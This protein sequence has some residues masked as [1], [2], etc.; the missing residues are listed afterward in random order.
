MSSNIDASLPITGSPTTQ[1]VRDNFQHAK[2]EIED[3]QN[4]RDDTNA[5][6]QELFDFVQPAGTDNISFIESFKI[7]FKNLANTVTSYFSNT[8]TAGRTYLFPDKSG[9]VAMTSDI[10]SAGTLTYDTD[11]TLATNSDG[12]LP[13]QKAVK[14]YVDNAVTGLLDFKG[15]TNCSTNPN[16]PAALKGDAYIVTTAGK[17]GGT[18][19]IIVDVSDVYVASADNAGGTQATVGA[20]WFVLEHN[21]VGAELTSNKDATGGYTGLTLFKINFKNAANTFISFFT[22]T[23]TAA[24]TY[25][26]QDRDGTIADN[27]DLATKASLTGTETLT[28]KSLQ[29]STTFIVDDS[30]PT[31]KIKFQVSGVTTAT[32]R[33]ITMPDKD[34]TLGASGSLVLLR[35]ITPAGETNEDFLT[36]F[37]TDYDNYI[38]MGIGIVPSAANVLRMRFAV[39]GASD[40]ASNYAA[41]TTFGAA[42]ST[43]LS[44]IQLTNATV[45]NT[46]NGVNFSVAIRNVND[47]T[48]LKT[49]KSD[50]TYQDSGTPSWK[51]EMIGGVYFAANTITGIRIYWQSGATFNAVGKIYLYGIKNN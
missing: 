22:N 2:D 51:N 23:N 25:T 48:N 26:F 31:K 8:N 18:S 41:S 42:Y 14:T 49:I 16:Y 7:Q 46:G 24:R 29:D 47:A 35:T 1:S 44:S 50:A 33:T 30:D 13:T 19:G 36:D 17:I 20:S 34:V 38:I 32:T 3:L 27:T 12:L 37:S 6:V 11:T 5:A 43:A 9:T 40:T 28:N 45:L 10:G 21:L 4:N 15:S 39:A